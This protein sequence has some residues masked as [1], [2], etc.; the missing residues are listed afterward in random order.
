MTIYAPIYLPDIPPPDVVQ[1]LDYEAITAEIIADFKARWEAVRADNPDLPEYDVEMLESDPAAILIQAFAYREM[2]L[3]SRVNDAARAVML[4]S[5]QG[6][7]L[8][9]LGAL[10]NTRRQQGE[11]D[12]RF[13]MRI[14]LAHERYTA[15]GTEA[16]Y[17]WH[18][19]DVAPDVADVGVHRVAPGKVDIIVLAATG[20]PSKALLA[21]VNDRIQSDRVK[22]L[23][24]M[25]SVRQARRQT[26]DVRAQLE[27]Y[28]S[29]ERAIVAAEAQKRVSEYAARARRLGESVM[30]SGLYAALH[31]DGVRRV[32][33]TTPGDDI[34][35]R[36]DEAPEIGA[37]T[38]EIAE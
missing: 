15:A 17:R 14:Q 19:Y 20:S 29:P 22:P 25:V 36:H 32:T 35:A 31:T 13:R 24:D 23:T 12:E 18:A 38:I 3:R 28:R 16:A 21:S 8:D 34:I 1:A 5:A 11:T 9:H 33:L 26:Y 6:G 7:D 30:R 2:L 27:I 10:V 4:A 37:L